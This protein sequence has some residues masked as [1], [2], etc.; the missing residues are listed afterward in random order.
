MQDQPSDIEILLAETGEYIETKTELWK[1]KG[2]DSFS[3]LSSSIVSTLCIILIGIFFI[4]IISIGFSLLIGEWLG[5][6]YYGFFIVGG[7]YG[8]AGLICYAFRNRWFKEPV[9]NLI[10]KKLLK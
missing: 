7:L 8:I 5:K 9:S 2:V 1:L 10:I 6:Y 3:D 4:F